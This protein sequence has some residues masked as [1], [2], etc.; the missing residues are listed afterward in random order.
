MFTRA[1]IDAKF[2]ALNSDYAAIAAA[3]K[4]DRGF[5]ERVAK[6]LYD[7]LGLIVDYGSYSN[8]QLSTLLAFVSAQKNDILALKDSFVASAASIAANIQTLRDSAHTASV[9][10]AAASVS[11]YSAAAASMQAFEGVKAARLEIF[12]TKEQIEQSALSAAQKLD[13]VRNE[14]VAAL[15]LIEQ[16]KDEG[17]ESVNIA[18]SEA[19]GEISDK[20]NIAETTIV[21]AQNNAILRVEQAKDAGRQSINAL[22]QG[23]TDEFVNLSVTIR[24]GINTT[25]ADAL[26]DIG[27]KIDDAN[28]AAAL[29]VSKT[30]VLN[31]TIDTANT[32]LA[33]LHDPQTD[34]KLL[35]IDATG[36]LYA[37]AAQSEYLAATAQRA[38]ASLWSV[39]ASESAAAAEADRVE[40]S[41]YKADIV[42][43]MGQMTTL[44]DATKTAEQNAEFIAFKEAFD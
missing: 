34:I 8:E 37:A 25:A 13:A 1:E 27:T 36:A 30:A 6:Y 15:H 21:A 10:A 28:D 23:I 2:A 9:S 14:A 44:L 40:I 39:S 16:T 29:A 43:M 19:I 31:A 3:S 22:T 24:N 7:T 5:Y 17:V 11:A 4:Y 41:G 12:D 33:E 20:Q 32:A 35:Y 42:T 38:V 26:D 18:K